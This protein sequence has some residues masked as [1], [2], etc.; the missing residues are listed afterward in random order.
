M[1]NLV[2]TL[3]APKT[4]DTMTRVDTARSMGLQGPAA[5]AAVP[6]LIEALE[7]HDE[8]SSTAAWALG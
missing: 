7:G 1:F 8:V 6:A 5:A 2:E 3:H 4:G